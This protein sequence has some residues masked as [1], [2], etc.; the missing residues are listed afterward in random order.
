MRPL[1]LSLAQY[2][3][4]A[5]S[6][7]R[8]DFVIK[9]KER[10]KSIIIQNVGTLRNRSASSDLLNPQQFLAVPRKDHS[11]LIPVKHFCLCLTLDW[12]E[13]FD[14]LIFKY[15]KCDVGGDG[16]L[17]ERDIF[18]SFDISVVRWEVGV[19]NEAVWID[20]VVLVT[21]IDVSL[22]QGLKFVCRALTR[23]TRQKDDLFCSKHVNS[24]TIYRGIIYIVA[25]SEHNI[26]RNQ[27]PCS[28]RLR[29]PHRV[30]PESSFLVRFYLS[31]DH[32]EADRSIWNFIF[33]RDFD[34]LPVFNSANQLY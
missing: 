17:I 22:E 26:R 28:E 7:S 32:K 12:D 24:L 33:D 34:C 13:W 1:S 23:K 25:A 20:H 6:V 15:E 31:F 29:C 16:L 30:D 8:V 10:G 11:P 2:G 27:S 5:V 14:E 4:T 18:N 3:T 19:D 9:E 21:I